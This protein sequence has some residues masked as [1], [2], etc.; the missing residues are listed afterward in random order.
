MEV[1]IESS[2]RD[3]SAFGDFLNRNRV[4][5]LLKKKLIGRLDDLVV[6]V[7]FVS[8]PLFSALE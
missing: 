3:A 5:T 1:K 8:K 4:K 7:N 6:F 2:L